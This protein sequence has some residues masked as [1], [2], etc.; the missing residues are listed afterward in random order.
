MADSDE[1]PRV[2]VENVGGIDAAEVELSDGVSVLT[3]RN[4]T[5]RTSLLR[6]LGAALGGG[7]GALKADADRGSVTLSLG[8]TDCT[9][10]FER[11]GDSVSVGGEPYTTDTTLVD[12]YCGLLADNPARRAVTR[13]TPTRSGRSSWRPWTPTHWRRR[14]DGRGR[15]SS[16][17]GRTARRRNR[18]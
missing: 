15:L 9:R 12:Q 17:S 16:R 14:F 5:N 18:R 4:A 1:T 10:T 8:G 11:D 2:V 3:G 7:T 13:G 6:A